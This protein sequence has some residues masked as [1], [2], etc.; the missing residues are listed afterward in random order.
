M[1]RYSSLNSATLKTRFEKKVFMNYDPYIVAL[2]L[3]YSG[4]LTNIIHMYFFSKKNPS[5][6][7]YPMLEGY[8]KNKIK[9]FPSYPMLEGYRKIKIKKVPFLPQAGRV[10]ENKNKKSSLPTLCWKGIGK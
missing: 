8:W 10:W 9:K 3:S 4:Q 1:K 6:V 2:W 7:S 5:L